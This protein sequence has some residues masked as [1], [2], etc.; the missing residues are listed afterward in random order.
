MKRLA[1]NN[2]LFTEEMRLSMVNIDSPGTIADFTASILN[3]PREVQQE[4]LEELDV[5]KRMEHV[6]IYIKREQDLLNIQRKV[7]QRINQKIEKSQREYFLREEIKAIKKELGEPSDASSSDAI[8]LQEKIAR[9]N[10][11]AEAREQ[12]ESEWEKFSLMEPS[13]SEYTVTRTYL[14]TI[15]NLPWDAPEPDQI[16][17]K[18]AER[19]LNRGHYGLEDAKKTHS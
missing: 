4:I 12:V 2:P 1:E 7:A 6:L 11:S 10:L 13:S 16:S 18:K 15:V 14:D 9:L 17:L 5:F 19:I 3:L 8:K